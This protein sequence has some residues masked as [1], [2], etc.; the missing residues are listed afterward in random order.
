MGSPALR[1]LALRGL[2][3]LAGMVAAGL[4]LAVVEVGFRAFVPDVD[5]VPRWLPEKPSREGERAILTALHEERVRV[6]ESDRELFWRNRPNVDVQ[7]QGV[8][9]RTNRLGLRDDEVP[10]TRGED[11]L[12]ILVLGESTAFG[13]EVEQEE[14]FVELLEQDLDRRLPA[15]RVS[16]INAA[17]TGYSLFQSLKYL[18]L[19]GLA[20]EPDLVLIYHGYN[21]FLPTTYVA[22]RS[23]APEG[24]IG[25]T[26][27]ELF[28]E[29]ARF[30]NRLDLYLY[31]ESAAYRWLRAAKTGSRRNASTPQRSNVRRVPEADRRAL[32]EAM[33]SLLDSKEI[34]LVVLVPA[35]RGF[36]KHRAALIEFAERTGRMAID[37]RTTLP[38]RNRDRLPLFRHDGVHPVPL[39]HARFAERISARL[40]EDTRL[41]GLSA[42]SGPAGW[43]SPPSLG[44]RRR[45][46]LEAADRV[47]EAGRLG[48]ALEV[49]GVAGMGILVGP[50]DVTVVDEKDSGHHPDVTGPGALGEA[51][52]ARSTCR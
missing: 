24:Q 40:R 42:C 31:F 47:H 46:G 32:L 30:P 11:E 51:L 2:S 26:D 16:V 7:W 20:L 44:L 1:F 8:R 6:H 39:L 28:A 52:I 49:G 10:A 23:G 50:D 25:L 33:A 22:K 14:S 19:R 34:P 3:L 13:A 27:R 21:D 4:L 38:S 17:V 12:R 36:G 48:N 41:R 43:A 5:A 18:E 29:R 35:Y 45:F 9:I 37:L 15:C